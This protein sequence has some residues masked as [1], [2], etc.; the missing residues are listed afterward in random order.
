MREKVKIE[1]SQV[2]IDEARHRLCDHCAMRDPDE[3]AFIPVG[4]DDSGAI[5]YDRIP[6]KCYLSPITEDG[7]DCSYFKRLKSEKV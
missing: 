4:L 7:Q 5:V 3:L 6:F 2:L 1:P